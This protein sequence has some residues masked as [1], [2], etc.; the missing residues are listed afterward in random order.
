MRVQ[1]EMTLYTVSPKRLLT[2][3]TEYLFRSTLRTS[4]NDLV[5]LAHRN[6]ALCYC[7]VIVGTLFYYES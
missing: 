7:L 6:W 2:G 5:F 1:V 3:A 4:D